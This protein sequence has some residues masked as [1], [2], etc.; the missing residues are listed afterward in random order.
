MCSRG[1]IVMRL[2]KQ[3]IAILYERAD[4]STEHKV[5]GQREIMNLKEWI[6]DKDAEKYRALVQLQRYARLK[7]YTLLMVL[8]IVLHKKRLRDSVEH[9]KQDCISTI[10]P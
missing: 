6:E 5:G 4:C 7:V 9:G 2:H 8:D 1:H 10:S 3:T